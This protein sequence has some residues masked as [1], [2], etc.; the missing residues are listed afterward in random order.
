MLA[1]S[2][3]EGELL[4]LTFDKQTGTRRD[5]HTPMGVQ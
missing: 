2:K 1:N 3:G 5:T 4:L